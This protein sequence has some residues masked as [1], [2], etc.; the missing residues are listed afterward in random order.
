MDP[1]TQS[2]ASIDLTALTVGNG[3]TDG[4]PVPRGEVEGGAGEKLDGIL[5]KSLIGADTE[6]G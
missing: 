5:A 3:A 1:I 2:E 6:D 4:E